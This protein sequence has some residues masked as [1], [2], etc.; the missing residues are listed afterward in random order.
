LFGV[1]PQLPFVEFS[2]ALHALEV[3]TDPREQTPGQRFKS[4]VRDNVGIFDD[5]IFYSQNAD[6][7]MVIL[8][9]LLSLPV[10]FIVALIQE[11]IKSNIHMGSY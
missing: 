10:D 7:L 1:L 3:R 4:V 8:L 5:C 9:A 2:F 11:K 6:L